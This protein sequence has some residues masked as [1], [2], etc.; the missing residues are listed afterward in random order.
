MK[1]KLTTL[2]V[3]LLVSTST[4]AA[5]IIS[6]WTFEVNTPA[7]VDNSSVGPTIQAD[8]GTGTAS[9]RHTGSGTDWT[10]PEGNGSANSLNVNSWAVGDYFQFNLD[11]AGFADIQVSFDQT[12]SS[13]GPANFSF[14]YS[15]DGTLFTP[16]AVYSV[17]AN[18]SPNQ[19]NT[20]TR[21][22]LF[23]FDF[24]LS[25]VSS[26]EDAQNV[27]F[28]IVSGSATAGNGTS[29]IDNFTV[30]GSEIQ[31]SP[32]SAPDAGGSLLLLGLAFG[33]IAGIYRRNRQ[34][35]QAGSRSA[36]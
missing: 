9:G 34:M 19:W 17:M 36:V 16:F 27:Y 28:R 15:T 35:A 30:S 13:T 6:Q 10:T 29:R 14:A 31:R 7:N 1:L 5:T 22:S 3:L 8:S 2:A 26:L 25:A 24:D 20:T 23:T 21:N 11:T 32:V 12:R 18:A 4:H 33:G